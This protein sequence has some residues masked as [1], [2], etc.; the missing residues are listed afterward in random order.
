MKTLHEGERAALERLIDIAMRDTG[1]SRRVANFLLAWWDAEQWGGFDPTDAWGVDTGIAA[2]M[3]TVFAYVVLHRHYPDT[4]G[5]EKEFT[6]LT[7][8]WRPCLAGSLQKE[9][10]KVPSSSSDGIGGKVS[11]AR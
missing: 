7:R 2:D 10:L 6:T 4:L 5:Y 8:L 9:D 11:A 3:T 1:Q